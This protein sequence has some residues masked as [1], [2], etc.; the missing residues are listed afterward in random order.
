M[1]Q[2]SG[3]ETASERWGGSSGG[4]DSLYDVVEHLR[5]QW[6]TRDGGRGADGPGEI[7]VY[8]DQT[9]LGDADILRS[10][11]PETTSGMQFTDYSR[12][13]GPAP[14]SQDGVRVS[15]AIEIGTERPG[16]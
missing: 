10:L 11:S 15:G 12:G 9:L 5:P 13:S 7:V 1:A 14:E 8:R 4:S 2:E 6:L 3:E 16:G